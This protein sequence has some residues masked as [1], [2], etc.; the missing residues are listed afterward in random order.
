MQNQGK[1]IDDEKLEQRSPIRAR[2]DRKLSPKKPISGNKQEFYDPA[3][4]DKPC[5]SEESHVD[6]GIAERLLE[7]VVNDDSSS[8]VSFPTGRNS[9]NQE[10]K[11]RRLR[12]NRSKSKNNCNAV[13]RIREMI[14]MNEVTRN[15]K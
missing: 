13:E 10:G 9:S 8:E 1:S 3:I 7:V 2:R 4:I 12:A 6:S 5:E 15:L 14:N 11:Q